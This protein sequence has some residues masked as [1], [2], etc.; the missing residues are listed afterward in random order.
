MLWDKN[1]KSNINQELP[2]EKIIFKEDRR[3]LSH[4]RNSNKKRKIK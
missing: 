3:Y 1:I 4:H 2:I